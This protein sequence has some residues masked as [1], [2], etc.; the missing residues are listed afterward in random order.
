MIHDPVESVA[1]AACFLSLPSRYKGGGGWVESASVAG[2]SQMGLGRAA[3]PW[4][5]FS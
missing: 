5:F 1:L 4:Y 3:G 2:R